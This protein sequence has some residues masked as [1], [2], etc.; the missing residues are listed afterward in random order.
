MRHTCVNSCM[1]FTG[2]FEKDT[3][4]PLLTRLPSTIPTLPLLLPPIVLLPQRALAPPSNI[5]TLRRLLHTATPLLDPPSN[6]STFRRPP[7]RA[8][9]T[10]DPLSKLT[11]LHTATLLSRRLQPH[12]ANTGSSTQPFNV[13]TS[14]HPPKTPAYTFF[15]PTQP[16]PNAP[17][18][19]VIAAATNAGA[20]VQ[21]TKALVPEMQGLGVYQ[22]NTKTTNGRN[23][24]RQHWRSSMPANVRPK[25]TTSQFNAAWA[26]L[27]QD[28]PG[29]SMQR[30]K[31]ATQ[32]K[33]SGVRILVDPLLTNVR[34]ATNIK[35]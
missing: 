23:F 20:A 29:I 1:G 16:G 13:P 24:F 28:Q 12:N 4:F 14:T 2:P 3:V 7:H 19:H 26:A 22:P 6:I 25:P 31:W 8:A 30:N 21:F 32:F 5:S 27:N 9:T 33:A 10:L 18:H 34:N 35:Y 17:V 11:T 15:N